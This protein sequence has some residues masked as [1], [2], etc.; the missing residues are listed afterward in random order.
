[1]LFV[2]RQ[3]SR[4]D[5]KLGIYIAIVDFFGAPATWSCTHVILMVIYIGNMQRKPFR[6]QT[7]ALIHH[8][9]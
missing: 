9:D 8:H 2:K 3:C 6:M 7:Y 5:L 4:L 1:M